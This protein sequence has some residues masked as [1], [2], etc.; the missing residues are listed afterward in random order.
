MEVRVTDVCLLADDGTT[1]Q[2]RIYCASGRLADV[3]AHAV[4]V[5]AS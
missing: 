5:T 4:M 2:R 1:A 3:V